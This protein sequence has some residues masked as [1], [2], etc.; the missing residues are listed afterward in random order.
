MEEADTTTPVTEKKKSQLRKKG[1]EGEELTA[2]AAVVERGETPKGAPMKGVQKSFHL[3][4]PVRTETRG[5]PA[6]ETSAER[7]N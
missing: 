4:S 2:L 5:N 1:E 6:V 7:I 3:L